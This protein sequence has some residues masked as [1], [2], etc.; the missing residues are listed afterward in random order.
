VSRVLIVDDDADIRLLLRIAL[1]AEGHDIVEAADGRVAL[2][3]VDRD[4]PDIV[5]LDLMMPVVDGWEF[6]R[7]LGETT[8][9]L[10]AIVAVTALATHDQGH[11]INLLEGGALDVVAKPFDT[12]WLVGLVGRLA[13]MDPAAREAHRVGRLAAARGPLTEP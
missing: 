8:T 12:D 5:L 10:P 4:P 6:L 9:D 13:D 2:E 3:Q 11:L 7:T 1:G